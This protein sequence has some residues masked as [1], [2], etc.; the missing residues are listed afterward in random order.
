MFPST[1]TILELQLE[2][3]QFLDPRLLCHWISQVA[4]NYQ[5]HVE[6]LNCLLRAMNAIQRDLDACRTNNCNLITYTKSK[7]QTRLSHD[8]LVALYPHI[9][10]DVL[11]LILPLLFQGPSHFQCVDRCLRACHDSSKF[12]L[13]LPLIKKD[14][15]ILLFWQSLSKDQFAPDIANLFHARVEEMKARDVLTSLLVSE[16]ISF[17]IP[18]AFLVFWF[19]HFSIDVIIARASLFDKAHTMNENTT[20]LT[21][22]FLHTKQC[23]DKAHWKHYYQHALIRQ[24]GDAVRFFYN[25][26]YHDEIDSRRWWYITSQSVLDFFLDRPNVTCELIL[27]LLDHLTLDV[28]HNVSRLLRKLLDMETVIEPRTFELFFEQAARLGQTD[29]LDL[30]QQQHNLRIDKMPWTFLQA[31]QLPCVSYEWIYKNIDQRDEHKYFRSHLIPLAFVHTDALRALLNLKLIDKQ[32]FVRKLST[33]DL[34][35]LVKNPELVQLVWCDAIADMHTQLTQYALDMRVP[36]S[37]KFL[38][39]LNIP[40]EALEPE[41]LPHLC[42]IGHLKSLQT[43]QAW[44]EVSVDILL[45]CYTSSGNDAVLET[46]WS[47]RPLREISERQFTFFIMDVQQRHLAAFLWMHD[48]RPMLEFPPCIEFLK[49]VHFDV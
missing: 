11:R 41:D 24:N 19:D 28:A 13:L 40:W 38:L 8:N 6:D 34:K 45:E 14:T 49:L 33:N 39:D 2:V 27:E 32:S 20:T 9:T 15:L 10:C 46:L 31:N 23:L 3:L 21:L 12:E 7:L 1:F 29:C 25:E 37:C 4:Q 26:N 44:N 22:R 30:L 5:H 42:R 17:H 16:M 18:I 43:F 47:L 36:T 35:R 48:V